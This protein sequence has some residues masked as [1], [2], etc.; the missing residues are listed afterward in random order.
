M[1][2]PS[3]RSLCGPPYFS[4]GMGGASRTIE[5]LPG[6][7]ISAAALRSGAWQHQHAI[8]AAVNATIDHD[9]A[10]LEVDDEFCCDGHGL[11]GAEINGWIDFVS[12][13][14]AALS[15]VGKRLQVDVNSY[16]WMDL[17]GPS[18]VLALSQA[19]R[20]RSLAFPPLL[21][22]MS[23]YWAPG[24]AGPH[25]HERNVSGLVRLGV[26]LDQISLGIGLVEDVGHE[27]A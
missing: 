19:G 27:N 11:T 5:V 14:S 4:P 24:S 3:G 22:D 7:G 13:L 2:D 16:P 20:N 15:R 21:M 23:T 1:L 18:H 6:G 10:G 17:S 8:E 25:N 9:W 12:S 26:P